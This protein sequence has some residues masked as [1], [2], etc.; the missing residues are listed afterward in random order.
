MSLGNFLPYH[1][2]IVD[3]TLLVLLCKE[4]DLKE[5]GQGKVFEKLVE[6]LK[7]LESNGILVQNE[8]SVFF[9][10]GDNLGSH[11]IGGFLE[12][13][14][15]VEYFCR[16][17]K[18]SA[19]EFHHD[20]L[21]VG[22]KRNAN[23]YNAALSILSGNNSLKS[24]DGIK[25][26]SV[27]NSL[28]YFHVADSGLPPC[29]AHD[30][31]EGLGS[32]DVALII[33]HLTTVKQWFHIDE[34]NHRLSTLHYL[35]SDATSKPC[36]VAVSG[37]KLGGQAI[38]NWNFIRLLPIIM[39]DRI[40]NTDD[41]YWHMFLLLRDIIELLCAPT[42]TEADIAYLSTLIDEYLEE[43]KQNFPDDRMKPKHHYF[44]HYP[45]LI[46]EFGPLIRVWTLRFESKHSYLKQCIKHSQNFINICK[47]LA[48][49]HQL[50]Q[51]YK[52]AVSF[53]QG[54]VYVKKKY[55]TLIKYLQS[56]CPVCRSGMSD[57]RRCRSQYRSEL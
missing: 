50:L 55:A 29:L 17:C 51:A 40:C 48:E 25:F 37:E 45:R 44:K 3:N 33:K 4:V 36:L 53:F 6:D 16:Y 52:Q 12:S 32:N 41:P 21:K 11:G 22:W 57:F 42:I 19:Q 5:F 31:F 54:V 23:N 9:I 8:K 10:T 49:K 46:L 14:S 27:F 30:I 43:R 24:V 35:G 18:V 20:P 56:G 2:S 26:N 1:R 13:F 47:T 38:Q 28:K 34:L 7:D 39:H 15:N